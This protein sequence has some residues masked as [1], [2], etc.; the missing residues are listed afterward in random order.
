M[1][2][3]TILVHLNN[4]RRAGPLLELGAALARQFEAHLVGLHVFPSFR[5][6]PP[7][8]LPFGG[9]VAG[10]IRKEIREEAERLR[11][12]FD[13]V[14]STQSFVAEWRSITTERTD[15]ATVVLNHARAA[16]LVIAS[17]ADPDWSFSDILDCPDR[18][19]IESGRPVIVVP[20]AGRFASLPKIVAIAW[21]GR[22]EA[23]R[24]VF[25]AM[26]L[27]Q[28]AELVHVLTLDETGREQEG[29]LPDTEIGATLARH[30][31]NVS[32][33]KWSAKESSAADELR[34]AAVRKHAELLVMGAYGHSR[35]NELVF[36]GATRGMLKKM[37]MP[38]LFSH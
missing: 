14:T 18:L 2:Y 9:E 22:R 19:A 3:K 5:L 28:L 4:E 27:L 21:N 29:S 6:T 23:A 33:G 37:T 20:R 38:V 11:A 17:Q 36:G 8:P 12:V 16:D 13:R 34:R 26:P 30:R 24:A 10:A 32:L 25:D 31:V 35:F 1:S 7:V 15:V